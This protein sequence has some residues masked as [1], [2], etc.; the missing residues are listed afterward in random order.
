MVHALSAVGGGGIENMHTSRRS[1]FFLFSLQTELPYF[2][3][4]VLY[5]KNQTNTCYMPCIHTHTAHTCSLFW[6]TQVATYSLLIARA[7]IC[8][9]WW[10]AEPGR[11][12]HF[13]LWRD[14]QS[15]LLLLLW[16]HFAVNT[17]WAT[18]GIKTLPHNKTKS[19][20]YSS[21]VSSPWPW[22]HLVLVLRHQ[23]NQ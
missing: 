8:K 9:H 13:P 6:F 4:I 2:P 17:W 11:P 5:N 18:F 14:N 7:V 21:W 3:R 10:L 12:N 1:A 15:I 16:G 23:N 22:K 19:S 20:L